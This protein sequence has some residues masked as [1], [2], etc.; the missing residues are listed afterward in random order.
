L[1]FVDA[2]RGDLNALRAS[3]TFNGAAVQGCPRNNIL[4][5]N[6]QNF[7]TLNPGDALFFLVRDEDINFCNHVGSY[8]ESATP[9]EDA[10]R[11]SEVNADPQSCAP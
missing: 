1:R 6:I 7:D 5:T 3:G 11:D 2:V 8:S 4:T 10:G 9:P